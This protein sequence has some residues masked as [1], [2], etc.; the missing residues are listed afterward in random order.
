MWVNCGFSMYVIV[1][2]ECVH[3]SGL[4][5]GGCV[6]VVVGC[7]VVSYSSPCWKGSLSWRA[8]VWITAVA[9]SMR[10]GLW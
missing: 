2:H 9:V 6:L 7:I 5:S 10:P 1:N 8:V 3:L 4:F